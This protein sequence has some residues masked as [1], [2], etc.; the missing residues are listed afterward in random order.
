MDRSMSATRTDRIRTAFG[1]A[2]EHYE[3]HAGVQ[4]TVAQTLAQHR[5]G[6][7]LTGATP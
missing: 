1:A 5:A 4:R 7:G 3:A 6:L 2:A